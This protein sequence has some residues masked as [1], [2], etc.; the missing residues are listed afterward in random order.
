MNKSVI[1]Y[2]AVGAAMVLLI[3][4]GYRWIV[5]SRLLGETLIEVQ[6]ERGPFVAEVH[7]TGQ[8]QAENATFIE[9]PAE[10]SSRRINIFEIQ[11]TDLV[12]E[13]TVV[14]KGDFVASLDHSAI[15]E[16]LTQAQ[17]DLEKAMQ[18]LQDARIDT[19]INMSNLRDGLL[20]AKVQ[21]EEKKLV[22]DQSIYESP[23]VKR[24]AALELERAEQNLLQ[25]ERNYELKERQAK[26]SVDRSLE[27]LRRNQ[28]SVR[29]IEDL[30]NALDITAPMPGMVIYSYDR[31]GTKIQV[32]STV[33]RWAPRIAELPDLSSMISKTYINEIDISKIKVGQKV[34]VGVDAFPDKHFDGEVLTVANIGQTLPNGDT[35]VFEVTIKLFGSDPE[36]R[37][38]M[39]T[40][41]VITVN[42][43]DEAL[44]LPLEAVFKTDS[45]R[46]VYTRNPDLQ[47]QIIATGS[48]NAN[49]VVVKQGLEEGQ[50][51]LLN[52][53]AEAEELPL[54]GVEIYEVLKQEAEK[55]AKEAEEDKERRPHPEQK[56]GERDR[57][58]GPAGEGR[59][60][61]PASGN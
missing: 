51:V 36:L 3:F 6:V 61:R 4:L 16:L 52:E 38:A 54:V 21:V 17:E 2:A 26:N 27:E 9:V 50:D 23:A 31:F 53:P 57:P 49:F 47:R 35:K 13:G 18:A 22:L 43:L 19:N 60:G 24:Q 59:R 30:F 32:G 45:T 25:L 34:E 7:S 29:D 40:S 44:Y 14:K 1:R 58:Q 20:N 11:V 41:N 37:P 42:S 39:T 8:L 28:E 55:A 10:L 56:E 12:E 48:E 15:E 46:F 5:S 33:S